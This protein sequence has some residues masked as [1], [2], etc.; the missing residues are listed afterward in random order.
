MTINTNTN[1][2]KIK[3]RL[4]ILS[5]ITLILNFN[6]NIII[7]KKYIK[8]FNSIDKSDY[9]KLYKMLYYSI[10]NYLFICVFILILNIYFIIHL[11]IHNYILNIINYKKCYKIYI[12]FVIIFQIF[13]IYNIYYMQ[14]SI[15]DYTNQLYIN[16]K[17]NTIRL[18]LNLIL[19]STFWA[20][21]IFLFISIYIYVNKYSNIINFNYISQSNYNIR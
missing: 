6:I 21:I 2:N 1:T 10:N 15:S 18:N 11:I 4:L 13:I 17:F 5:I 3:I 14:I 20:N 16:N 12:T 9:I 19:Q 8:K 7:Q